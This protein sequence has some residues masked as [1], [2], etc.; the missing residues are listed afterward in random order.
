M[1]YDFIHYLKDYFEKTFKSKITVVIGRRD[2][3]MYG[4]T[5]NETGVLVLYRGDESYEGND[6]TEITLY[7]ESWIRDDNKDLDKGYFKLANFERQIDKAISDLSQKVTTL[8]VDYCWVADDLQLL[9]L[10]IHKK[11][12]DFDSVRPLLGSQY[13]IK[14]KIYEHKGE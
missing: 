5:G 9:D 8:D 14:A 6:I 4:L 7:F 10:H 1:W 12:G 3:A 2:A 13:T 11:Q